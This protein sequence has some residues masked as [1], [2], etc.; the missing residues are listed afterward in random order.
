MRHDDRAHINERR[1]VAFLILQNLP[2]GFHDLAP[3]EFALSL[4]VALQVGLDQPHL[5]HERVHLAVRGLARRIL[6]VI[7]PA[8][9]RLAVVLRPVVVVGE[10]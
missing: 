8:L 10:L 2:A 6:V 3:L 5:A 9:D 4:V 1:A 7:H